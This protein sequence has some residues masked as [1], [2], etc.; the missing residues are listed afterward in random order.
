M[1][2]RMLAESH[3]CVHVCMYEANRDQLGEEAIR[4]TRME[5][6]REKMETHPPVPLPPSSPSL[7]PEVSFSPG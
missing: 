5:R 6:N 1:K 4:K 2:E 7:S 3:V